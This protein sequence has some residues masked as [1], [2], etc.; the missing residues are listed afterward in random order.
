[1]CHLRA[2]ALHPLLGWLDTAFSLQTDA[3]NCRRKISR[4]HGVMLCRHELTSIFMA[5]TV[6]EEILDANQLCEVTSL[7][8]N[9]ASIGLI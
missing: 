7:Q 8:L 1:M 9:F 5:L 4:V 2:A 3:D 6:A